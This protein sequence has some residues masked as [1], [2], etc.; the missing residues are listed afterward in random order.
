[1]EH[2]RTSLTTDHLAE[3]KAPIGCFDAIEIAGR[4]NLGGNDLPSCQNPEAIL[5]H[6]ST[7]IAGSNL[8]SDLCGEYEYSSFIVITR[9]SKVLKTERDQREG[10]ILSDRQRYLMGEDLDKSKWG[11]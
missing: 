10:S 3:S 2:A 5:G 7:V 4:S 8:L 11:K 9:E 6:A 1:M